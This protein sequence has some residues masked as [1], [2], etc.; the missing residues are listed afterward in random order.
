MPT[1]TEPN[2][3]EMLPHELSSFEFDPNY[4][5]N[6]WAPAEAEDAPDDCPVLRLRALAAAQTDE[7][8]APHIQAVANWHRK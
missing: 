7:E 5:V 3:V 1:P 8:R 6:C 2:S 4:C